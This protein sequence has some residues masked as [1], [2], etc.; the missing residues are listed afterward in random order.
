MKTN[1][2]PTRPDLDPG[3][4]TG[5]IEA[6]G[7]FTYCRSGPQLTVV[8]S[9]RSTA[10]N[11]RLLD[12][13][14]RFLGGVG[15]IYGGR[16][17]AAGGPR[18]CQLRVTRPAELLRLVEHL[19]AHPLRG[20]RRAVFAIWREMVYSRAANH[21]RRAP[22]ELEALAAELTRCLARR[23]PRERTLRA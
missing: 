10:D 7:V 4:I 18:P 2:S 11:S 9:L 16:E 21:G 22:G 23:R 1:A 19:E 13:I 17:P 14:R 6:S 5:F 3:Y 20:Q 12:S 15:R 8:F